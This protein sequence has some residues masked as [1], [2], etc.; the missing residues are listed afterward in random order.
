MKFSII[1]QINHFLLV[2]LFYFEVIVSPFLILNGVF[3]KKKIYIYIY[4]LNGV[5]LKVGAVNNFQWFH[6]MI[7][8]MVL[9]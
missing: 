7:F 5:E 1:S 6:Q 8:L 2:I 9:I 3:Q 4:I